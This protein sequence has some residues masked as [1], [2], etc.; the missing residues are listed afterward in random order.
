MN[1]FGIGILFSALI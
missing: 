1:A